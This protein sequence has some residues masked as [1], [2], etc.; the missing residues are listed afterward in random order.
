M[1]YNDQNYIASQ[2]TVHAPWMIRSQVY[3]TMRD[4]S[5]AMSVHIRYDPS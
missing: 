1:L 5:L 2:N 4:T 3:K